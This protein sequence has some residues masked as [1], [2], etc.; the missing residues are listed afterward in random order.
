M[1]DAEERLW[2]N[3]RR[4]GLDGYKFR[5]QH[6]L[7]PY[8]LD[9]YCA[10]GRLVVEVDG[11][12]HFEDGRALADAERTLYLEQRGLRVLRFTNLETLLKTDAVLNV[13]FKALGSPLPNPLPKGARGQR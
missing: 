13:I 5:R 9:F 4:H 12:Q 11:G 1:T 2:Y 8:I 10:K 3:L 6:P 7:G